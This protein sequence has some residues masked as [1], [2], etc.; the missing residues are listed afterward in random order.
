VG[1]HRFM[2]AY[3]EDLRKKVVE[4]VERRGMKK[5]EAAYTFGLSLS[6][7]KR[8]VGVACEGR[9][10]LPKKRP[11]M[12]P[13]IDNNGRRLLEADL[14][15]RPAATLSQRRE[16]LERVAGIRV[17]ESTVSR[18]LKRLGWTRKKDR[19]RHPSVTSG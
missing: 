15:E 12:R 4:A 9:S 14:Q 7:V 2:R 11:G 16:F 18:V 8:Y 17:S 3:S 10:L 19:W 13:K 1:H 6:S 5:S